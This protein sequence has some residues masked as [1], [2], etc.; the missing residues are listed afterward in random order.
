MIFYRLCKRG[1]GIAFLYHPN[2]QVKDI[3]IEKYNTFEA[4]QVVFSLWDSLKMLD[5]PQFIGLVT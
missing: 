3:H 2:R 1:G 4:Q 5:S